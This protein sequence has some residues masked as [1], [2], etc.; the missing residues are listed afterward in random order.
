MEI[1]ERWAFRRGAR[2]K[3]WHEVTILKIGSKI[4]VRFEADE[5]EGKQDWVLPVRLEVP[6]GRLQDRERDERDLRAMEAACNASKIEELAYTLVLRHISEELV[7][8][9]PR[10]ETAI[11]DLDR[12]LAL[13]KVTADELI[14]DAPTWRDKWGE[15]HVP[16]SV[17]ERIARIAATLIA[18]PILAHLRD[19][20][21]EER[22]KSITG[23]W[24]EEILDPDRAGEEY[25]VPGEVSARQFEAERLPAH[26]L[27]R[28]WVGAQESYRFDE[29][30]ALRAELARVMKI[31]HWMLRD[32]EALRSS[33]TAAKHRKALLTPSLE[34]LGHGIFE[35]DLKSAEQYLYRYRWD[36]DCNCTFG[37]PGRPPHR[38]H[39]C[40]TMT[41]NENWS[42]VLPSDVREGW[43]RSRAHVCPHSAHNPGES[44]ERS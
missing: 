5:F 21:H 10:G 12:L 29:V 9:N 23:H 2:S 22:T 7:E 39:D 24:A 44:E 25:Y 17:T 43:K 34:W 31:A 16:Q 33:K 15:L 19:I 36:E 8:S 28:K 11:L 30:E 20:E 38:E 1:G 3:T 42:R 14:K 32:L 6:W 27:V 4:K 26:T 13:L 35:W 37:T 40:M 18:A 41:E